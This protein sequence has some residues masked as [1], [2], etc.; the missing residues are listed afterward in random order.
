V[1]LI[2]A[3][4]AFSASNKAKFCHRCLEADCV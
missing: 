2:L 4:T 3:P 1:Q